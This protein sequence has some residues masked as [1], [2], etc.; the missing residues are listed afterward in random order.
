M[1]IAETT[2]KTLARYVPL[3]RV[4]LAGVLLLGAAVALGFSPVEV[5]QS[6]QAL[7][8][9]AGLIGIIFALGRKHHVVYSDNGENA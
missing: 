2:M 5:P 7:L 9:A 6:L 4:T 8:L 3:C 1:Q